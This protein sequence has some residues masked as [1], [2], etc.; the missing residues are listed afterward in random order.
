MDK[1]GHKKAVHCIICGV[2]MTEVVERDRHRM[3]YSEWDNKYFHRHDELAKERIAAIKEE[4]WLK[5]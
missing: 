2:D 5:K 4:R 1:G 3:E